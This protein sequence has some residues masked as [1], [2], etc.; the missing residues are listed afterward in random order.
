MYSV[1]KSKK[2]SVNHKKSSSLQFC[3]FLNNNYI[4]MIFINKS[5]VIV[6]STTKEQ[7]IVAHGIIKTENCIVDCKRVDN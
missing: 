4:L 1:L 2:M 5:Y 6:N 3:N 7:N